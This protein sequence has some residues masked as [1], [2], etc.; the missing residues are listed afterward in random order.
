M[1]LAITVGNPAMGDDEGEA[2]HQRRFARL[3]Q[4]LADSGHAGWAAPS[5][6]A[7]PWGLARPHTAGFPYG[8]LHRLQRVYALHVEGQPV[9]PVTT[10]SDLDDAQDTIAD[11]ASLLSSHLLCHSDTAGYFVPAPLGDPVFLPEEAG[12][13]GAGMVGSSQGLL[14]ELVR[15]AP[16]IG[17]RLEPDGTLS[18]AEADRVHHNDGDPFEPEQTAWLALHESCLVSIATGQPVVFH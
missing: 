16:L 13:A 17:V 1:G 12:V 15:I 2:H 10:A 8:Y 4:A 14:R 3:A 11:A 9:T 5:E 6:P 7:A 18:D